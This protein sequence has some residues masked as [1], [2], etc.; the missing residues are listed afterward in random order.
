MT[1][2]LPLA[3][4][5][6]MPDYAVVLSLAICVAI[7]CWVGRGRIRWASISG[8][9]QYAL[10]PGLYLDHRHGSQRHQLHGYPG[11]IYRHDLKFTFGGILTPLAFFLGDHCFHSTFYRLQVFTTYEFLEGAFHRRTYRGTVSLSARCVAGG[12]DLCPSLASQTFA[13]L[14]L[15]GCILASAFFPR[16]IL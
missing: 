14:P 11:W 15:L 10:A 16:F 8:G 2:V 12:S 3:A 13:D 7:G 5:C 4:G 1:T 6:M 9:A